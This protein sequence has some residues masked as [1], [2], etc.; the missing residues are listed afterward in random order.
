MSQSV[1]RDLYQPSIQDAFTKWRLA[2]PVLMLRLLRFALEARQSHRKYGIKAVVERVR[3][4]YTVER[5]E[6]FL[7][8]NSYVS[9]LA[10]WL[11]ENHKELDGL[12]ETRKLKRD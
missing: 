3:W 2:N 4:H 8:N 1:Q 5:K 12:F 7:I 11:M 10:R 6:E 9:R